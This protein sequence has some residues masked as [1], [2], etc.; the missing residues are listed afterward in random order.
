MIAGEVVLAQLHGGVR[1]ASGAW[2]DEADRLHR[3]EPQRVA[4]AVRHHF[5]RQAPLEELLFVEIVNSRRLRGHQRV[6]EA[7]VFLA[8]QRAVQIV[9]LPVVHAAGWTDRIARLKGSRSV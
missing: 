6:V 1:L 3:P 2:V 4:P 8:R 9:S 5:D 7:L